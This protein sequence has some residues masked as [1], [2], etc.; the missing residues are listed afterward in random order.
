[1][2]PTPPDETRAGHQPKSMRRSGDGGVGPLD[3]PGTMRVNRAPFI[4]RPA[5]HQILLGASRVGSMYGVVGY[6]LHLS[7]DYVTKL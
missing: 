1:M 7:I 4:V 3:L 2:Y 5:L 6:D